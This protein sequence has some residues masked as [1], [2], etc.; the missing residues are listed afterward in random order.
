MKWIIEPEAEN[1]GTEAVWATVHGE[2]GSRTAA[3]VIEHSSEAAV[4]V[5]SE[6]MLYLRGPG[7]DG[8]ILFRITATRRASRGGCMF[9]NA[10]EASNPVR[11]GEN[12]ILREMHRILDMEMVASKP[13]A[14]C[15]GA[16]S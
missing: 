4:K 9:V 8:N 14:L 2:P 15:H 6:G 10:V 16:A 12:F 11:S 5:L 1:T 3:F 13:S 7:T